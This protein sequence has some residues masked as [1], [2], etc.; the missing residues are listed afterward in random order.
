MFCWKQNICSIFSCEQNNSFFTLPQPPILKW[1]KNR[2][3]RWR[4]WNFELTVLERVSLPDDSEFKL[5]LILQCQ[6]KVKYQ[7]QWCER[8][9][10]IGLKYIGQKVRW[11]CLAVYNH[12]IMFLGFTPR[13]VSCKTK[14]E[15]D[16]EGMQGQYLQFLIMKIV[17][18]AYWPSSIA[19]S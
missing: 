15:Q 18:M 3:E 7:L 14:M 9:D 12:P 1:W 19:C 11:T 8:G 6:M 5:L 10:C 2:Q 13:D 4:G 17:W 16:R